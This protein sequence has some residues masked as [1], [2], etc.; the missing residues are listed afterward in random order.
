MD[1]IQ[2]FGYNSV[3]KLLYVS[4]KVFLCNNFKKCMVELDFDKLLKS[5][6]EQVFGQQ[7]SDKYACEILSNTIQ[8]TISENIS[9]QTIRRYWHLTTLQNAISIQSKN[10]LCRYIGF[11]DF[12]NFI[13]YIKSKTR[14][15][16]TT[17]WNIIKDWY[18]INEQ[19]APLENVNYWHNKLSQSFAQ[20]ILTDEYI[21][22]SFSKSLHNNEVALKY[23][24]SYHPMYDNLAK[25][26]YFRGLHLFIRNAKEIH[27]NLYELTL[28]FMQSVFTLKDN[29]QINYINQIEMLLPKVRK[30]YGIVW[31]LEARA[32][33]SLLFYFKSQNNEKKV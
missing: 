14:K 29:E 12:N 20:F 16:N 5:E 7:I 31:P 25:G 33:S 1:Y 24:I 9:Y 23:I 18:S 3:Q 2:F 26:W 21:F 6:V 27:Y 13:Q 32:L 17:N 15:E 11:K 22:D 19:D 28:L 4:I 8:K 10:I 30:K